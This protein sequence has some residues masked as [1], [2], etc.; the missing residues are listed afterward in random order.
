ME[1]LI[2]CVCIAILLCRINAYAQ[3][4]SNFISFHSQATSISQYHPSFRAPYAGVNSLLQN[5]SIASSLTNTLFF[6]VRPWKTGLIIFNPEVSGGVGFSGTTGIAG[7]PNGEIYRVGNPK[8]TIYL[9]R[10]I[11]EERIPLRNSTSEYTSDNGNIVRGYYPSDYIKFFAGRFTL[12]DYFDGNPYNHDPRT[13]FINWSFMSSGAWDYA[14]DTRGYTWGFG[15]EWKKKNWRAAAAWALEPRD[16]NG[17]DFDM[18]I[19][20]AYASHF[21]LTHFYNM[22]NYPGQIQATFFY[23]QARMGNYRQA[24]EQAVD[25]PELVPTRSYSHHK[26]GWSLNGAQQLSKHVGGFM[27]LSWNDGQ[28]ET[29]AFTEIDQSINFGIQWFKNQLDNGDAF[30]AGIVINGISKPHRDFL[31]AGGHGFIIGDGKLNYSNEIITELYYRFSFFGDH[32][33]ISPDYQFVLNPAY[34]KDRGPVNI[35]GLRTHI[36]L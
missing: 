16:A 30:G 18:N 14:A 10:L 35:F 4:D 5:E 17:L 27:R 1:K 22:R 25:T 28:N 20:Q 29:W 19:K 7:F 12:A 23:N 24:L 21:E 13:Q 31:A 33:Q 26:W 2:S 6:A 15:A 36:E 34:N 32:L 11:L 9:A 3:K 8:P